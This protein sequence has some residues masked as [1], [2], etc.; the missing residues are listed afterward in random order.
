M[1]LTTESDRDVTRHISIGGASAQT[2]AKFRRDKT[3][4]NAWTI[5][6]D[7]YYRRDQ[8]PLVDMMETIYNGVPF[9]AEKYA[10]KVQRDNS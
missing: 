9:P 8:A 4:A 2:A 1:H 3:D 5:P 6:Y 10:R 7:I